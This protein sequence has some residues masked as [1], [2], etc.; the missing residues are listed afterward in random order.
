MSEGTFIP[1]KV[2]HASKEDDG[3]S[4]AQA[5]QPLQFLYRNSTILVSP[6]TPITFSIPSYT[7]EH[8]QVW[9]DFHSA[10]SSRMILDGAW[11]QAV[12]W[13]TIQINGLVEGKAKFDGVWR[14][15]DDWAPWTSQHVEVRKPAAFDATSVVWIAGTV[16]GTARPGSVIKLVRAADKAVIS[17]TSTTPYVGRWTVT[18]ST[19]LPQGVHELLIREDVEGTV[20]RYTQTKTFTVLGKIR[21]TS[22]D[23]NLP[24][25]SVR[26]VIKGSGALKGANIRVYISGSLESVAS[27]QA[28]SDGEWLTTST[29]TF[30]RGARYT[31]LAQ[32]SL[33]GGHSDWGDPQEFYL[34]GPPVFTAPKPNPASPPIV[35][36]K[37]MFEGTGA[38]GFYQNRVDVYS[39]QMGSDPVVVGWPHPDTGV[40]RREGTLTPGPHS[41]FGTQTVKGITSINSE[42]FGIRVRPGKPTVEYTFNQETMT[43]SG[44][45]YYDQHLETQIQFA[46]KRYPGEKPPNTPPNVIV[47]ADCSWTTT[48]TGWT[49]GI[50]S[51][52]VV[53]KIQDNASG[54][55]E[56]QP[57]ELEIRNNMPDVT[58]VTYTK[59]YRP[60][61]SG[62]GY[63]GA[64][65]SFYHPGG[66]LKVAPDAVVSGGIWSS[67]ANEYWGPVKDREVHIQQCIEEH[68]SLNRVVL[69]VSIPPLPPTVDE[70]PREGLTPTF[71][72]TCLE[73]ATVSITFRGDDNVYSGIV[74]K[75]TWTFQRPEPFPADVSQTIYV[76][77]AA[78]GQNSEAQSR[79]FTLQ[80]AMLKPVITYPVE[81]A[82][83]EPDVMIQGIEGVSGAT[84]KLHESQFQQEIA[85]AQLVEGGTWAIQ[86]TGLKFGEFT[87]FAQQERN[88]RP[89][90]RSDHRTFNVVVPPPQIT[91]PQAG[92]KLTRT[93]T[94]RGTGFP[95]AQ[96]EVWFKGADAPWLSDITVPTS[97]NWQREVTLPVG[98]YIIQAR[99]LFTENNRTHESSFTE[100]LTYDVVPAAPFVETPIEG[101]QVGRQVVVSGFGVPGDTVT[102]TLGSAAPSTVVLDDR[103]WSI[104]VE[105]QIDGD[106]VLQVTSVLDGF[107]SGAASRKVVAGLY[108]PVIAEP[109]AGRWVQHPVAFA[110]TGEGGVGQI[111]SWFNP[112][113]KWTPLI[114]VSG[115]AWRGESAVSLAP[116]GKWCRF[117]QTLTPGTRVSDWAE[118]ARFEVVQVP[119]EPLS[120]EKPTNGH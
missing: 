5:W 1:E 14:R 96:V 56:S 68:C 42:P 24:V 71:R 48:S 106:M 112:E 100:D 36:M 75:D 51:V 102:V 118:S 82:D 89:S 81:S 113:Q 26:P 13:N 22:P 116:G 17:T 59:A 25:E 93:A 4:E 55:I 16:S 49:F 19:G 50:Y 57:Y 72:G 2:E 111:V 38:T 20:G 33:N 6:D 70:P 58:D 29:H 39:E 115:N 53:L 107:E 79:D 11:F 18:L 61:F 69:K 95:S 27:Y 10:N 76:T 45:G 78:A 8:N 104:N 37:S 92:D 77:Q 94:L 32:Q 35:D 83:V 73:G 74:E 101:E 86:L 87:I 119:S 23:I 3:D 30:A 90:E 64:T 52:E 7:G 15:G 99:Q 85:E 40:W 41:I 117:R 12:H 44:S 91:T 67:T 34:I 62:K 120:R 21:I 54:W 88:G 103:T 31:I 114:T 80:P 98:N 97:G 84:M 63:N 105:A 65:V 66:D 47:R 9:M 109:A 60:V 43:F 110:G 108:L 28:V 46:I